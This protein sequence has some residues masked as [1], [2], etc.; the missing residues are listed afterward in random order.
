CKLPATYETLEQNFCSRQL[1]G[2]SRLK[3][4]YTLVSARGYGGE[5]FRFTQKPSWMIH[6]AE[7]FWDV[8][9]GQ[10]I[11]IGTNC[12]SAIQKEILRSYL[13]QASQRFPRI[14]Q[15]LKNT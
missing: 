7:P 3:I 1:I 14:R 10:T 2:I 9:K 12:A 11:P 15:N 4:A 13:N 5:Q 6:S 8:L